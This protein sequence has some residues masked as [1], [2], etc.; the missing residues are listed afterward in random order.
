M[1]Q[2]QLGDQIIRYDGERTKKAY[3]T[4]TEGAAKQ[5]GCSTC[6]NFDAQ[7]DTAFPEDFNR[8]LDELGVDREKEADA[9]EWGVKGSL[10]KCGGW[11]HLTGELVEPGERL[12]DVVPG[13]QYFFRGAG[14]MGLSEMSLVPTCS[15]L[16]FSQNYRG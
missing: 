14:F 12:T 10:R 3:L 4:I 7:R 13:F 15:L 9:H 1:I 16:S 2:V 11:F 5:C 8:L 6:R